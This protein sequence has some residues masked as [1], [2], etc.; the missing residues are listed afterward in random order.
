MGNKEKLPLKAE[1]DYFTCEITRPIYSDVKEVS[2]LKVGD[3]FCLEESGVL[4]VKTNKTVSGRILCMSDSGVVAIM[5]SGQ[6]V[7]HIHGVYMTYAKLAGIIVNDVKSKGF[8]RYRKN[9]V[10]D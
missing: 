1:K 2:K 6:L 3:R 7:R 5:D 10:A 8:M 4:Y 9:L